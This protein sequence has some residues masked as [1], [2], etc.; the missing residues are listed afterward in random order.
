MGESSVATA[1]AV[2]AHTNRREATDILQWP[3]GED[4]VVETIPAYCAD[5][6]AYIE[7]DVD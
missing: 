2:C 3:G 1:A 5:C 4:D 6:C 7:E